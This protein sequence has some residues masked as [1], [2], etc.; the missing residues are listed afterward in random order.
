MSE[1]PLNH[2]YAAF[3]RDDIEDAKRGRPSFDT[4]AYAAE[5]G[6]EYFD[7]PKML[8]GW[9]QAMSRFREYMHNQMR[10]PLPGGRYGVLFHEAF[11][12][13][14]RGDGENN[15]FDIPGGYHSVFVKNTGS[16]TWL[17]LIPFIGWMFS[18]DRR[19]DDVP[20]GNSRI[21]VPCTVAAVHVPEVTGVAGKFLVHRAERM[22][23]DGTD[24]AR[25]GLPRVEIRAPESVPDDLI[26]QLMSGPHKDFQH[27][28]PGG[29][30]EVRFG[31]GTL[32]VRRNGYL[33]VEE[34]DRL[35][36]ETNALAD[37]FA[38]VCGPRNDPKPFEAELPPAVF[39]PSNFLA[40]MPPGEWQLGAQAYAEKHGLVHE[41][42]GAFNLAF[43][44][45][46]HPGEA[47]AVMRAADGSRV[48]YYAEHPVHEKQS[49]RGALLL[50]TSAP[51]TPPGG[52]RIPDQSLVLEVKDGIAVIWSLETWGWKWSNED[53]LIDRAR[54]FASSRSL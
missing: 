10:G 47:V 18:K 17:N 29:Y 48:V 20:F 45:L 27:S 43:P 33:P 3:D 6:L 31:G 34:M 39:D 7:E 44:T 5:H 1:R 52:E 13:A 46:P 25:V 12:I 42:P 8:G 41:D 36:R 24:L 26:D 38:A 37:H 15:R 32:V 22:P 49:V 19:N 23:G 14:S 28:W 54:A 50:K 11:E 53:T 16:A 30:L 21:W 2:G 9:K 35:A 51:D 40:P 4:R